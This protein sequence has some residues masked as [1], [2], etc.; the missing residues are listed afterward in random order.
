MYHFPNGVI[1]HVSKQEH[2]GAG[3]KGVGSDRE[4]RLTG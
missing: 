2:W 3:S 4:Y 1:D